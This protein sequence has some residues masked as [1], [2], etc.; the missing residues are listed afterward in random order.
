M[1]LEDAQGLVLTACRV[2]LSIWAVLQL[3]VGMPLCFGV[4]RRVV[5]GEITGFIEGAPR[6][7][8]PLFYPV[9][10]LETERGFLFCPVREG[11][12]HWNLKMGEKIAVTLPRRGYETVRMVNQKRMLGRCALLLI[13]SLAMVY[14]GWLLY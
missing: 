12:K 4:G 11:K 1:A 3:V 14:G 6:R 8:G 5:Q 10:R 2:M 13:C 9:V 7:G